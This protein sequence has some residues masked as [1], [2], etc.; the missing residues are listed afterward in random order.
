MLDFLIICMLLC[1]HMLQKR[2]NILFDMETWQKLSA[3]AKRQ[4]TS[5]G[6]LTR[7]A[8]KK[9]YFGDDVVLE[10]RRAAIEATLKLRKQ[11]KGTFSAKEIK[12]L[13]NYGRKY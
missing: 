1:I 13:I 3:L 11:I 2:T 4:S 5:V 10:K 7:Q 12:E 9:T 6:E 8:I